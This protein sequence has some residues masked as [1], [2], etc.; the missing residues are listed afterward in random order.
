MAKGENMQNNEEFVQRLVCNCVRC[1]NRWI[2]RNDKKPLTCWKCGKDN[3][4]RP[5][6]P[7]QPKKIKP[8][9]DPFAK[10]NFDKI[11]IGETVIMPWCVTPDGKID[12]QANTNRAAALTRFAKKHNRKFYADGCGRGLRIYRVS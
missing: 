12:D 4:W 2:A 6:L 1:G 9:Y 7:V 5:P 3:W 10:Y 11:S 8:Q